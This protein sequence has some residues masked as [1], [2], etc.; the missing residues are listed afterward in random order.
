MLTRCAQ[1][2]PGI[3]CALDRP[4]LTIPLL[5]HIT[6]D[7]GC[8]AHLSYKRT[9]VSTTECMLLFSHRTGTRTL[10]CDQV[11]LSVTG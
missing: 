6:V 10:T 8:E 11:Q 4:T 3:A 2:A 9:H 7:L 5:L 1:I